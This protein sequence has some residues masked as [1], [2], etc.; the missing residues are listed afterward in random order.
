MMRIAIL[1]WFGFLLIGVF[2]SVRGGEPSV[3]SSSVSGVTVYPDRARVTRTGS[4]TLAA[5]E[6]VLQFSDLPD[7]LEEDSVVVRAQSD[8]PVTIEGIDIRHEFLAAS[9]VPKAQELQRQLRELEDQQKSLEAKKSVLEESRGFFRNLSAGLSKGEKELGNL[10]DIGKLY[11]Y[12][13]GEISK[14]ADE[15]L[16]V[17]RSESKLQPEIDRVRRELDSLNSAEQ[18]TQRTVFASVKAEGQAKVDFTLSYAIGNAYWTPSYDARVDSA[19]GKVELV[20]NALVRQQTGED[21]SNVQLV[22]S[23][24]QP[25]RNGKMPELEPAFVDFKSEESVSAPLP[26]AQFR[27]SMPAPADA[28]K[29]TV[30]STDAHAVVQT[31]GLAVSYEVQLPVV[32]PADGQSHRTNVLV[33]NLEGKPEYVTTP[34]LDLGVF[35]RLHLVNTSEALL[36]PGPVS[37]FR[38]G[39]FTGTTPM[40]LLPSGGDF[41]LYVGKDDSIRVDRKDV[42]HKRS[43]TGILNRKEVEDATYQI[44]VQNFRGNP[45]KLLIYDQIPV[46]RNADLVVNQGAFSDKPATFDKDSG[47]LT[48]NID[49]GPKIKKIIEFNYSMEWPKGKEIVGGF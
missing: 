43:E 38:D 35:L 10:D 45:I 47:K 17:Q 40:N 25:G 16:S 5:G 20:Y 36:L 19:S 2:C 33:V 14:L 6:S 29:L 4:V 8:V 44:S 22:L 39:E 42:V 26:G 24:A 9:A 13:V 41:D 3:V 12:Y 18:K 23:T 34:K 32:I 28:K 48:W 37:V 21:W 1:F 46:S 49:L 27:S 7:G 11:A 31:A 15:I 30:Q